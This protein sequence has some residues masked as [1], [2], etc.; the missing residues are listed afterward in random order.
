MA[1]EALSRL[2]AQL[3]IL[4]RVTA[5]EKV[6]LFLLK[7][8]ERLSDQALDRLDLPIS[9]YDIAG[10]LGLSVETV[11]RSLTSLQNSGLIALSSPVW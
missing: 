2:Q 9:P 6:G 10:C 1:F 7:M 8:A 4:G 5:T 3:K 11:I